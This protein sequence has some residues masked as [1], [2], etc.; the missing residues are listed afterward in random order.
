M[1]VIDIVLSTSD[2]GSNYTSTYIWDYLNPQAF[3]TDGDKNTYIAMQNDQNVVFPWAEI[4]AGWRISSGKQYYL[5]SFGECITLQQANVGVDKLQSILDVYYNYSFTSS[6][7]RYDSKYYDIYTRRLGSKVLVQEP[8]S[9]G[10]NAILFL[11]LEKISD[12]ANYILSN[13][14]I[15]TEESK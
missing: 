12:S 2:N 7:L 10:D 11:S 8:K 5:P 3:T 15:P 9:S 14:I 6:F 13:G 1:E 4:I